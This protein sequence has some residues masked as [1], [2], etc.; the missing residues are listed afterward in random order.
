MDAEIQI[1]AGKW[2]TAIRTSPKRVLPQFMLLFN[3]RSELTISVSNLIT[4]KGNAQPLRE[5]LLIFNYAFSFH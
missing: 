2:P 3:N 1:S 4:F 5:N